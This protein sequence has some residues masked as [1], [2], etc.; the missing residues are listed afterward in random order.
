MWGVQA[1]AEA[2]IL[3]ATS[4]STAGDCTTSRKNASNRS[5]VHKGALLSLALRPIAPRRARCTWC[6][7]WCGRRG[8]R[9]RATPLPGRC[10]GRG[11][12]APEPREL[13]G[14]NQAVDVTSG[15]RADG[16]APWSGGR[17]GAR[18]LGGMTFGTVWPVA[19]YL[20]AGLRAT[21]HSLRVKP[22]AERLGYFEDRSEAR[23]P[24]SA[25]RTVKALAAQACVS[26]HL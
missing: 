26:C 5:N 1:T 12:R 11:D 14:Q 25:E 19:R 17:D 16:L 3:A 8:R 6:R 2:S 10:F 18:K 15:C 24:F 22:D 21:R 13:P 9:R 4:C 7:S 23:I 20:G